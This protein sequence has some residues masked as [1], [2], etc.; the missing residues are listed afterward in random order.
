MSAVPTTAASAANTSNAVTQVPD[1]QGTGQSANGDTLA[2]DWNSEIQLISSLA[3]LQELERKVS[4]R[5]SMSQT[6]TLFGLDYC[7]SSA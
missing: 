3:K 6:E 2:V 4:I 1:T 7:W 5:I